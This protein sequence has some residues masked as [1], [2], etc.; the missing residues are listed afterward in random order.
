MTKKE[1]AKLAYT[2][3]IIDADGSIG[4]SKQKGIYR[5]RVQLTDKHGNLS[6]WLKNNFGGILYSYVSRT[7]FGAGNR[8]NVWMMLDTKAKEF[9]VQIE[10][11]LVDKRFQAQFIALYPLK[12]RGHKTNA[13]E[14]VIRDAIFQRVKE[15]NHR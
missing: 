15:L 13:E 2:A 4:I 3:G 14:K 11:Y 1:T 7:G 5:I 9:I 10:P 12:V 6:Q 8:Y